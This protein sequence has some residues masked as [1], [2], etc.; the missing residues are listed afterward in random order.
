M[1]VLFA[2]G[3]TRASAASV[4]DTKAQAAHLAAQIDAMAQ[5]VAAVAARLDNAKAQLA[6]TNA[7][8]AEATGT[9]GAANQHFAD[10]KSRMATQAVDAY[11]HGGGLALVQQ[12]ADSKGEDLPVRN[13]YASL[14][15]GEDNAIA[16]ELVAA[17][18]DL[19]SKQASLQRL[20]G[21][22]RRAVAELNAQQA[23]LLKADASMRA[24][25]ARLK[26]ELAALVAADQA[27][28]DAALRSRGGRPAG[29]W[30]CIRQLESGNNYSA[31]GGGAYQFLDSTWHA[32]GHSGTASDA[33]PSEQ[34]AAAVQLQQQ[35]GWDQWTTAKRCGR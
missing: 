12:L 29:T 11:V 26:G 22:Q 8:L 35:A 24:L 5:R 10:I 3:V 21:D 33:P 32:L 2:G 31:P 23:A 1:A 16:D 34:D 20:Q 9:L 27:R 28:R 30:D 14:A 4:Q 17:R 25:L 13:H 7:A 6:A 15:A 19:G 18:Q